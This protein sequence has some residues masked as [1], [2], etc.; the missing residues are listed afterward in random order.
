M[1]TAQS[2]QPSATGRLKALKTRHEELSQR[3]DAIQ[4]RPAVSDI[5]I[6]DIKRQKLLLKDEIERQ[7]SSH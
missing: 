3:L 1:Q 4:K 7:Q 6:R 2:S 5:D